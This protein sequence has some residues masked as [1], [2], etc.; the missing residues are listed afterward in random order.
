MGG[1]PSFARVP[2]GTVERLQF[3][4]LS[5]LAFTFPQPAMECSNQ[6]WTDVRQPFSSQVATLEAVTR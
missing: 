5:G 3:A 1:L 2:D 6:D 4:R